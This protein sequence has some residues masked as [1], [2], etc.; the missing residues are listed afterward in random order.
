MMRLTIDAAA[1]GRAARSLS[2]EGIWI[3][4]EFWADQDGREVA[5][6][7]PGAVRKDFTYEVDYDRIVA[8]VVDHLTEAAAH[9]DWITDPTLTCADIHTRFEAL[10]PT[11][12][13]GPGEEP[14]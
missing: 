8:L 14:A 12:T 5:A 6:E 10:G 11:L 9:E 3:K 7:D 1:M 2:N 13:R 4:R